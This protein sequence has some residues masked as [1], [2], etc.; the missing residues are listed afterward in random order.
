MTTPGPGENGQRVAK[1]FVLS[2]GIIAVLFVL[3]K[4]AS[5]YSYANDVARV[6]LYNPSGGTAEFY[7]GDIGQ[8]TI[9]NG[10]EH[11]AVSVMATLDTHDTTTLIV[12]DWRQKYVY[13][14]VHYRFIND[15]QSGVTYLR[16]SPDAKDVRI[17]A[18]P[19]PEDANIIPGP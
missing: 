2:V 10:V 13:S 17:N 19:N 12:H 1:V 4:I 15:W 7:I 9:E 6:T 18:M 16:D 14:R 5:A 11:P 8:N 3:F